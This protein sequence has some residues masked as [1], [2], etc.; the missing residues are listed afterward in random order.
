MW[1]KFLYVLIGLV[2]VSFTAFGVG[3]P[4]EPDEHTVLLMH[5]DGDLSDASGMTAGGTG[6]GNYAFINVHPDTAFHQSLYLVNSSPSDSTCIIV[7]DTAA[8]DITGSFTIECWFN[9]LTVGDGSADWR[10][11]PRMFAKPDG[12]EY[13]WYCPNYWLMVW[14]GP[15]YR[16]SAGYFIKPWRW[17]DRQTAEGSFE[18]NKWY[19]FA[20]VYDTTVTPHQTIMFIHDEND[21]LLYMEVY[22]PDPEE[23][24]PPRPTDAPLY[25]GFG[26]GG[27][28][29]WF[30]GFIDEIRISNIA[31]KFPLPPRVSA[32]VDYG[33]TYNTAGPYV[34]TSNVSDE[35][36]VASVV[37]SYDVGVGWIDVSMDSI[38]NNIYQASIPGQPIGTTVKYY[39]TATDDDANSIT[40]PADAPDVYY[41]FCILPEEVLAYDDG[42]P[43]GGSGAFGSVG[44]KVSVRF[45]TFSE[46]TLSVAK[47]WIDSAP[48]TFKLHVYPDDGGGL[49]NKYVELVPPIEVTPT[50]TGWIDINIIAETGSTLVLAAQDTFHIAIEY[51]VEGEPLIGYDVLRTYDRSF[52]EWIGGGWW[53]GRYCNDFLIRAVLPGH[54][55][56]ISER[57]TSCTATYKLYQNYPNPFT[58]ST[59][60]RLEIPVTNYQFPITL[61]IYD[62]TGRIVH[63]LVDEPITNNQ[64]SITVVWDGKDDFGR[65]LPAG[66]YFY[67]IVTPKFTSTKKMI[68]LR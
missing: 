12:I 19:H 6:Q 28:D 23:E 61:A 37:L 33:N 64:S 1:C 17:V 49:P 7:P 43:V 42:I 54:S 56:G 66:I 57:V 41:G 45:N 18:I 20:F 9:M 24:E 59:V 11:A 60:I 27:N 36:K 25:I 13:P 22:N 4:Y 14:G 8:L 21:S 38:G 44:E 50:D 52:I 2:F 39:I 48:T 35:S 30:D 32:T 40:D 10:W 34:I 46:C 26:G 47:V 31:R 53:G 58:K 5:F 3:G 15:Y 68:L 55:V 63:T 51:L 62:L 16:F 65:E 29:S 67:R